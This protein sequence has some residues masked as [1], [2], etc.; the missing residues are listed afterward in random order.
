MNALTKLVQSGVGFQQR[1][2]LSTKSMRPKKFKSILENVPPKPRSGWQVYIRENIKDVK[3][4]T[5]KFNVAQATKELSVKWGALS[6]AEK[7]TYSD[8]YK[9]ENEIH[10]EAYEK[11][12][13]GATAEQLYKENLLR[14]KYK[15]KELPD[16]N[17]PK[18][19]AMNGYMYYLKKKR[20]EPSFQKL[21]LMEQSSQAAKEY[22]ELP[23]NEK[24][25]YV[26]LAKGGLEK[27]HAEK[28][29]YLARMTQ[30]H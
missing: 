28:K 8:I 9:K 27:Y 30:N 12:I 3:P 14:R 21:P 17:V 10:N 26:D 1:A 20:T 2:Y 23:E 24:K 4:T 22:K 13:Q 29:E 25:I 16:P 11:A 6:D 7:Q 19:P 18:R 5:G 15:L